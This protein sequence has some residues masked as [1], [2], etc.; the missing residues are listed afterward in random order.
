VDDGGLKRLDS[1]PPVSPVGATEASAERVEVV[2]MTVMRK[3]IAEHMIV[4]KR[5][6]AHVSTVFEVDMTRVSKLREQL[7][8]EFRNRHGVNLTYL[9][10]IIKACT[11][12]LQAFPILNASVHEDK[13]V[14]KKDITIGV[15]VALDWGLIVPVIKNSD[16]KSLVGLAKAVADLAARAR[17]KQLKPDEVQGGTFTI[18]N[19]GLFGSLF[20]TPIINQPQVAILAVGHITKRPIV[21]ADDAIAIR[22]M[23]YLTLTFDHRIIDGAVADQFMSHVKRTL[24]EFDL[25]LE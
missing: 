7:K 6:S 25:A 8:L 3:K 17:S 19:P 15:A 16:E 14:Y 23:V 4:S 12:A 2:P 5:T 18:T 10:F 1:Q 24:E 20:G 11:K 21:T 22:P 9:P 13:I